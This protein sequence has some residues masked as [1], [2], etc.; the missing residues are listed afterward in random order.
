VV[1]SA[2]WGRPGEVR[3]SGESVVRVLDQSSVRRGEAGE[4]PFTGGSVVASAA[5]DRPGKV[6]ASG[7]SV[8]RAPVQSSVRRGEAG[9]PPYAEGSAVAS[10][11]LGSTEEG[12]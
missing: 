9:E 7:E 12:E 1:A 8:V 5:W 2:T 3:A 4:P 10:A 6:R 11:A